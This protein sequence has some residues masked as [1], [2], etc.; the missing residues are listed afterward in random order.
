MW[1][2]AD[3]L[4]SCGGGGGGSALSL[5]PAYSALLWQSDK[6]TCHLE[7]AYTCDHAPHSS[8]HV[9]REEG[10][11]S[12]RPGLA[13]TQG[14]RRAPAQGWSPSTAALGLCALAGR[15]LDIH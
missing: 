12:Q 11:H 10:A 1:R 6:P 5:Q 3:R 2:K 15:L 7:A 8:S 4:Q 13:A 9:P 14:A